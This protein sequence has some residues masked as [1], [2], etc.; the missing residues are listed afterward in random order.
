MSEI[1]VEMEDYIQIT[2]G[3]YKQD[4]VRC[5]ECKHCEIENNKEPYCHYHLMTTEDQYF[6]ADGKKA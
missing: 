1:I 6:C 2:G 3:Q 4:L 5:S